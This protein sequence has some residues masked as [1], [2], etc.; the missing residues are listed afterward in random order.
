M[1]GWDYTGIGGSRVAGF[2]RLVRFVLEM[3]R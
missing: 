1:V 3:S 2:I